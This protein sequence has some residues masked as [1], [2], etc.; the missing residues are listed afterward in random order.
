MTGIQGRR[1]HSATVGTRNI[2]YSSQ[3]LPTGAGVAGASVVLTSNAAADTWGLYAVLAAATAA[4]L[5]IKGVM[6]SNPNAVAEYT[7]AIAIG[8]VGVEVDMFTFPVIQTAAAA[9]DMKYY[10][11]DYPRFIPAGS[12][13][14]GRCQN[15]V[16]AANTVA[17]KLITVPALA[18]GRI[19][20]GR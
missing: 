11:L 16:A 19:S 7:I 5:D 15:S 14:T 6:V 3:P 10:W 12:R 13:L 2:T 8:G 4:N 20:I 9:F 17:V 18:D 1:V